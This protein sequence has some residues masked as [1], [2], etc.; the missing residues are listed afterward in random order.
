MTK[1]DERGELVIDRPMKT[2]PLREKKSDIEFELG[3][4]ATQINTKH[5]MPTFSN[6]RNCSKIEME[7]KF[8]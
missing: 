4:S 6:I 7:I 1:L 2:K 8:V 3:N 5:Y